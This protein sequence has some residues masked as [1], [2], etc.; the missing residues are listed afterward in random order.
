MAQ[1]KKAARVG[2]VVKPVKAWAWTSSTTG[3]L[4]A[5]E[6]AGGLQNGADHTSASSS[7]PPATPSRPSEGGRK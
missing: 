5:H 7:P 2:K 6:L 1:S 4:V 3:L